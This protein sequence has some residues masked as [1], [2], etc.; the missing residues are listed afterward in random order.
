MTPASVQAIRPALDPDGPRVLLGGCDPFSPEVR[1]DPHS[2]FGPR[3]ALA[4]SRA[5]PLV[6]ADTGHHRVVIHSSMPDEDRSPADLVLGQPHFESEA[7]NAGR[8]LPT[9]QTLNV[10]VGLCRVGQGLAV[11][12]AWNN[13]VLI[14]RRFP[15]ESGQPADL[16]LGQAD[17]ESHMPNRGTDRAGPDTLHWP[18]Q[19]LEVHGSLWVADTGNRR[20]LVWRQLPTESGQPADFCVG[21]PD[22]LSRADNAGGRVDAQSMRW[23]HDLTP[24]GTDGVAVTDA[25]NNRVL[26]WESRPED[27]S[28]PAHQ[29]LGQ[30]DAQGV[31]HNQGQYWPTAHSLNMPY[32]ICSAGER[33]LI[34]DTANSRLIG[35]QRVGGRWQPTC[36]TGQPDF[37][38]KGDNRNRLPVRD[39]L[40]WPYGLHV[41]DGLAFVSDTG[42]HR[43][44]VWSMAGER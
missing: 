32:G 17:F 4:D 10:P 36:L 24:V 18:F 40:C 39:S 8:E 31:D 43:V 7:R 42:N 1:P 33:L 6:V 23:P 34:A 14:W 25:G 22:L 13:R 27:F 38:A 20:V 15:T 5:G 19:V 29:V 41:A 28:V 30:K 2:L 44:S 16:V 21:Q 12:D 37:H 3:G 11:A 9:A 26:L 35:Y